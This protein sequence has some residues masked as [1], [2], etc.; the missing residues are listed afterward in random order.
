MTYKEKNIFSRTKNYVKS[1]FTI[2][3]LIGGA[4]G[5]AA[6][7]W[8]SITALS[9][10]TLVQRIPETLHTG[11]LSNLLAYSESFSDAGKVAFVGGIVGLV[12]ARKMER[13]TIHLIQR[14]FG[15][16]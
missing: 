13:M 5:T 16:R 10:Y 3:S 11:N 7:Y 1:Y 2:P 14:T 4:L 6:G 9:T 8:G 15:G 12:L